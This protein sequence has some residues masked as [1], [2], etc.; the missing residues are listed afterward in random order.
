MK[1]SNQEL[2]EAL[3]EARSTVRRLERLIGETVD[4]VD[5]ELETEP[6]PPETF[7]MFMT[8]DCYRDKRADRRRD[9]LQRMWSKLQEADP[10]APDLSPAMMTI[11]TLQ[12]YANYFAEICRAHAAEIRRANARKPRPKNIKKSLDMLKA[13]EMTRKA[14]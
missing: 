2:R 4:D 11:Q 10:S 6:M 14:A 3:S 8:H 13:S 9:F 1:P 5:A 12:V 7:I